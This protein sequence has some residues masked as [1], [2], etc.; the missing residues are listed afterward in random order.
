MLRR[1]C[2]GYSMRG[3]RLLAAIGRL[4]S[5]RCCRADR[6]GIKVLRVRRTLLRGGRTRGGHDAHLN[7][8]FHRAFNRVR[9]QNFATDGLMGFDMHGKAVGVIGTGRIGEVVCR[10]LTGFGCR[11]MAFDP[12]PSQA[13][14]SMGVEFVTK[15]DLYARATSSRCTAH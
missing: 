7:R 12:S 2:F 15:E 10:I 8:K 14:R 13:C 4:Q 3:T 5:R 1:P 9:E 6:L 11:V